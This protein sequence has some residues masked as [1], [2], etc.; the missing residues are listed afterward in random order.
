MWFGCLGVHAVGKG[1]G[2]LVC[3]KQSWALEGAWAFAKGR[4]TPQRVGGELGPG[5]CALERQALLKYWYENPLGVIDS[6]KL[7]LSGLPSAGEENRLS[8]H[9]ASVKHFTL[10]CSW[11]CLPFMGS[12]IAARPFCEDE[13]PCTVISHLLWSPPAWVLC[14]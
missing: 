13:S 8:M 9:S 1:A 6:V 11:Y 3:G 5:R 14:L 12:L 10:H 7:L 2:L 4:K